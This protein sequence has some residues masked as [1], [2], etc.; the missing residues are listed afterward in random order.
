MR[1]TPSYRT[2][3]YTSSTNIADSKTNLK[4]ILAARVSFNDRN[5]VNALVKPNEVSGALVKAL[6]AQITENEM[7]QG[8]LTSVLEKKVE[9]EKDMYEPLVRRNYRLCF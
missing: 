1:R 4:S 8:F 2:S 7:T 9:F 3:H 5:I 6:H